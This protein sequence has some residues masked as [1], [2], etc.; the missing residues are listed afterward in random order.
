MRYC[1]R[2]P[3]LTCLLFSSFWQFTDKGFTVCAYNRTTSKVDDFLA[4]E[5]K[6]KFSS[7]P[8]SRLES[9]FLSWSSRIGVVARPGS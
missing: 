1:G 8:M 4:N 7:L 2:D 6:G 9:C 3:T 5:A